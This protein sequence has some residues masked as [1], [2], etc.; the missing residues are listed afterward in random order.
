VRKNTVLVK[1]TL[2]L[3]ISVVIDSCKKD[4]EIIPDNNAPYYNGIPTVVVK[5]YINRLF[6]DLIGREPL[7]TEM[8]V[9]LAVLKTADLSMSSR[10]LLINKLQSNTNFIQGDSSY[11]YA[12]YI[13]FYE[14]SKARML[15]GASDFQIN[16]FI[17]ILKS[18]VNADSI[19]GDNLNMEIGKKQIKHLNEILEIPVSYL[20]DSIKINDVYS[21]LLYNT[22]YDQINM[23]TF[24]FLM[25][26]FNDLFFRFPTQSE[27]DKGYNMIEFDKPEI[28]FGVSG[29]NKGDYI[30]LLVSS[31]EFS[32]GMIK[33]LYQTLLAREPSTTEVY[34]HINTFAQDLDV[35]KI[36]R[37][38][39]RTD[40]YAQFN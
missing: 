8:S 22:V 24:N 16:E 25:A 7:D 37:L 18:S 38:I 12:Y 9:E 19:N 34:T 17:T 20:L 27:F 33:W 21:R 23:N 26:S 39:L 35:Q 13:R 11:K 31:R 10:D 36:Q 6:I 5:N 4:A 28:L 2:L 15:E 29:Q 1:L 40:E 30:S 32:E 3:F 14:L